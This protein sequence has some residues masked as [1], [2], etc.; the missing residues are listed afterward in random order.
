LVNVRR[1]IAQRSAYPLLFTARLLQINYKF[2]QP[3]FYHF[4]FE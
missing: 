3:E 4:Y 2:E 1:T